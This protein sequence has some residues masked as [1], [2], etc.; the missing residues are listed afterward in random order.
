VFHGRCTFKNKE[1]T[2]LVNSF[3]HSRNYMYTLP[4]IILKSLQ[5]AYREFPCQFRSPL[6]KK[7]AIISINSSKQPNFVID[8]AYTVIF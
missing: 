3:K 5:F 2:A 7:I 4:K 1:S 6:T 8:T